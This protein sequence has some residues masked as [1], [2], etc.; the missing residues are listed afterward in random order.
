MGAVAVEIIGQQIGRAAAGRGP[1]FLQSILGIVNI[2]PGFGGVGLAGDIAVGVGR[3]GASCA[4]GIRTPLSSIGIG[5]EASIET[6]D[7]VQRRL[8]AN[9]G[10]RF[11]A[12]RGSAR[13][14][15]TSIRRGV[16]FTTDG[17][18][19]RRSAGNARR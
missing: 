4:R 1:V 5:G 18:S 12:G 8:P 6:T 14:G 17:F 7:K 3:S 13:S 10:R 11:P 9:G 15:S 16:A 2:G 19:A